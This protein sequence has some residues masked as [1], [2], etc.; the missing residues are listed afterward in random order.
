MASGAPPLDAPAI[1]YRSPGGRVA[2][3]SAYGKLLMSLDV[4]A[5]TDARWSLLRIAGDIPLLEG[6]AWLEEDEI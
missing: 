5:G 3:Y 4:G 6:A 1:G 2:L